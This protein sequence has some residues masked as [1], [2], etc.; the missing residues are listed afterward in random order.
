MVRR[1]QSFDHVR[2]G[3][4]HYSM[5]PVS[6]TG[7]GIA[8]AAAFGANFVDTN[9]NGGF[10]PPVLLLR[11]ADG[12][13]RPFPHLFL[14]RAKTGVIAVGHDGRRFVNEASS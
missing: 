6:G 8:A 7:G 3:L 13:M 2:R 10:W 9:P 4:L 1:A 14:D 11:N 5:S 12:S